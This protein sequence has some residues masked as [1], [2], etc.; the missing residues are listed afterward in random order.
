[1][2]RYRSIFSGGLAGA[3][4]AI[5]FAFVH[6]RF[7][8]DIWNSLPE[9]MMAGVICGL[10]VGWTYG[11]LVNAPSIRTWLGYNA[12]YVGMF[13]F[14][15]A[16]SVLVFEP[17]A[18][19]SELIG[20]NGPPVELIAQAMPM[21]LISTLTMA[22][23]IQWLYGKSWRHFAAVLLTC[24]VLVLFLGLNVSIIGLVDIPR[25]SVYLIVE[26]FGLILSL[27]LVYVIVFI[28]LERKSLIGAAR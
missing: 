5:S 17:V 6:D 4:S 8:S 11:L 21:T 14:I 16:V 23:L 15:G 22:A 9:L 26:L 25:S 28:G 10:C 7:I 24:V 27:N 2:N 1:M 19:M 20:L 13:A 12:V 18:L 3:I